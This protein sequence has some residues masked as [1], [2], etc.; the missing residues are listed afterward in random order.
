MHQG[1]VRRAFALGWPLDLDRSVS[2]AAF[3]TPSQPSGC[4]RGADHTALKWG[5]DGELSALDLHR[6]L[7]RLSAVDPAA[8]DLLKAFAATQDPA[9][10]SA[11]A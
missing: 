5:C 1:P 7:E 3:P 8:E 10:S 4:S 9:P 6:I 2:P 11:P